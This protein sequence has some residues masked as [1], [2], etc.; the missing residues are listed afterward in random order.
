LHC[1]QKGR[2]RTLGMKPSLLPVVDNFCTFIP[3]CKL[4]E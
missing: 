2:P 4:P 3:L 1:S